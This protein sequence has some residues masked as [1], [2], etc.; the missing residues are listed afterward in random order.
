MVPSTGGVIG[1]LAGF[2]ASPPIHKSTLFIPVSLAD[3]D[4]EAVINASASVGA[5]GTEGYAELETGIEE[6]TSASA[7]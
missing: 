2:S 3:Q 1:C 6:A 7:A 5:A 4:P